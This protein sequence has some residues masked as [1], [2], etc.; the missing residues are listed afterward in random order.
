[1]QMFYLIRSDTPVVI[2]A[3]SKALDAERREI[4]GLGL[5]DFQK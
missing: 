4:A 2:V 3:I 5:N 1:M